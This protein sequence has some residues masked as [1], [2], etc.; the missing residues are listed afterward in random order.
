MVL[1]VPKL[2]EKDTTHLNNMRLGKSAQIMVPFESNLKKNTL[3]TTNY[4][5]H[6]NNKHLIMSNDH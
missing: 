5:R 1:V 3:T 2:Q 4:Y 6:K